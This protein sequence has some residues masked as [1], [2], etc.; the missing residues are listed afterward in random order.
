MHHSPDFSVDNF[1][2]S[3]KSTRYDREIRMSI[4]G[5]EALHAMVNAFLSEALP[6][7]AHLL[8]A[9]MGTGME[10]LYLGNLHPQWRFTAFDKSPEMLAVCRENV[11][12]Q[13]MQDRVSLI[14]GNVDRLPDNIFYDAATSLLVSHFILSEADRLHYFTAIAAHLKPGALFFTAD[15]VGNKDLPLYQTFRTAWARFNIVNGR[16][17]EELREGFERSNRVVSFLPEERYC[18]IVTNAGFTD[19]SQFYR[20]LLFCGWVC[21]K[22][23]V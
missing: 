5:Y 9:G 20:A 10:L 14:E 19:V 18:G 12:G 8:I 23:G 2:D 22:G 1:F 6:P 17:P 3:A 13:G 16:D 7:D 4:P 11:T 21:R 15:L